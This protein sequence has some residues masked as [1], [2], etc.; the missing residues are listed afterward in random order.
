M[1]TDEASLAAS[2]YQGVVHIF[3]STDPSLVFG[4]IKERPTGLAGD[5]SS[6]APIATVWAERKCWP[7]DQRPRPALTALPAQS[8]R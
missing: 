3:N 1:Q 7:R 5:F 6:A 4:R 2:I 8:P